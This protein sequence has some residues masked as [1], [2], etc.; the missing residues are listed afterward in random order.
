M[1]IEQKTNVVKM[2]NVQVDERGGAIR[3]SKKQMDK[4]QPRPQNIGLA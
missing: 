4:R 1:K 2:A 3:L